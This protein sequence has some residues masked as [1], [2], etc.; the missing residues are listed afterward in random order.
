MTSF[1]SLNSIELDA[2]Q[3]YSIELDAIQPVLNILQ[4]MPAEIQ[5]VCV[6]FVCQ[7]KCPDDEEEMSDEEEEMLVEKGESK[8]VLRVRLLV[9]SCAQLDPARMENQAATAWRALHR[10]G[11]EI[12]RYYDIPGNFSNPYDRDNSP[13][14]YSK[15][16]D[17]HLFKTASLDTTPL[18]SEH[19]A[20]LI[21]ALIHLPHMVCLQGLDE[22]P[23]S[24]RRIGALKHL[25]TIRSDNLR[26]LPL[27]IQEFTQ[28]ETM[29]LSCNECEVCLSPLFLS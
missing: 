3:P 5:R 21:G 1:S 7:P 8:L 9:D 17:M 23:Q 29:S 26:E 11:V 12:T 15:M 18:S 24:I 6:L 13:Y 16:K 20:T 19:V 28:L 10:K 22:V 27:W 25:N 2:I 4:E 14:C